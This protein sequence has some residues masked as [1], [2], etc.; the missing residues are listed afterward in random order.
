MNAIVTVL[1]LLIGAIGAAGVSSPAWIAALASSFWRSPRRLYLAAGARLLFGLLLLLGAPASRFPAAVCA[2][3]LVA[4]ASALLLPI[5]GF[6]RVRSF[7]DWWVARPE[8]FIRG[9][10]GFALALGAFLV[11]AGS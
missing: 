7:V 3:G 2:I 9:W 8:A 10:S 11:W 5:V 1:G 4:V 6:T